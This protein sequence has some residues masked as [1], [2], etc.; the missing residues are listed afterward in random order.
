MYSVQL[1]TRLTIRIRQG[2]IEAFGSKLAVCADGY[3]GWLFCHWVHLKASDWRLQRKT[4]QRWAW[5]YL[6]EGLEGPHM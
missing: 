2:T 6:A 4:D 1:G 3:F 5:F